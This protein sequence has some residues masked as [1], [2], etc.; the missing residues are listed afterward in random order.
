MDGSRSELA[1]SRHWRSPSYH[2]LKHRGRSPDPSKT[3]PGH[4]AMAAGISVT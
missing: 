1:G 3:H 4:G 2:I